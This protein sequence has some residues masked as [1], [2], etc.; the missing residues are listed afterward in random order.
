MS[1]K[2]KR[3]EIPNRPDKL[4][5]GGTAMLVI[6]ILLTLTFVPF[7]LGWLGYLLWKGSQEKSEWDRKY[8]HLNT[9]RYEIIEEGETS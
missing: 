3:E 8:G 1:N 7:G 2:I 5:G 9:E 4:F 6:G